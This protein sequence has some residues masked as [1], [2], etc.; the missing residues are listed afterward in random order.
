[1]MTMM[2][3]RRGTRSD[4][5]D[6]QQLTGLLGDYAK[7][8]DRIGAL[9]ARGDLVR[10]R[11]GLYVFGE[12]WRRRAVD[13]LQLA[14]LVYGPS[15]VSLDSALALHGLIPER[16]EEVTSVTTGVRRRFDTPF[17]VFS[18]TPLP[19]H[20]YAPG[21]AWRE[22]EGGPFLA[23]T[24]EKALADKVWTDKRFYPGRLGDFDA[25]LF[26][27]LRVDPE[28]LGAL[29]PERL[30]AVARA[31]GSKKVTLLARWLARRAEGGA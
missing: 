21:M 11:K 25:Y 15:Y 19:P 9:T 31:Y 1:M 7:P 26:D 6:Y 17:G 24:P 2:D 3:I 16:V 28:R 27:D 12:P 22:G 13:R 8:R 23:A 14:N 10:V 30:N 18:Y 20:R 29:A 4:V 5:L